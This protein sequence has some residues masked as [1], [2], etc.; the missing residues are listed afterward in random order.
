MAELRATALA[1]IPLRLLALHLEIP[2]SVPSAE[3]RMLNHYHE[4]TVVPSTANIT[5]CSH[6]PN[7]QFDQPDGMSEIGNRLQPKLN[8]MRILGS[9]GVHNR[10]GRMDQSFAR[11]DRPRQMKIK[12]IVIVKMGERLTAIA[13]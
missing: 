5:L 13:E 1:E 12:F 7:C 3:G 10:I 9:L 4:K 11:Y 6:V 2:F 8:P